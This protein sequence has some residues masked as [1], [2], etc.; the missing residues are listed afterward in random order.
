VARRSVGPVA[1]AVAG[2]VTAVAVAKT[3]PGSDIGAYGFFS[4]PAQSFFRRVVLLK[5]SRV[6]TFDHHMLTTVV[7]GAVVATVVAVVV[8]RRRPNVVYGVVAA[9]VVL[10]GLVAGV[11]SLSKF[12][13][14]AGVPGLTFAQ[15]GWIDRAVGTHANVAFAPV[16]LEA[17][18]NELI[19]FNRTLGSTFEPPRVPLEVDPTTG[20]ITG[21]RRYLLVQDGLLTPYGF[22]GTSVATS[23]YL[24]VTARLIRPR[25]RALWHLT[26][27][28]SVRV[29]ATGR[30]DCLGVTLAQPEGVIA[31]QRFEI[32]GT[33]GVLMGSPL[34]A[35]VPLP[36]NRINVDL[37]LHG[38]A[39]STIVGLGRG[40]CS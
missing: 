12:S 17:V 22:G 14:Q 25:P 32:G 11:Y 29:F 38:A 10:Y 36:K 2:V 16:G 26:S 35:S 8:A 1:V 33:R 34:T 40:P 4:Q 15:Q 27:P 28:R 13:K 23:S 3:G 9:T 24:P 18:Q 6:L 31:H 37:R 5:L 21:L 39:K 30:N 7:I 19:V 20:T